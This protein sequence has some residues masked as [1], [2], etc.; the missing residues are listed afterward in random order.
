MIRLLEVEQSKLAHAA[1][2]QPAAR[3]NFEYGRVCGLYA[4]VAHAIDIIKNA[5]D[6]HKRADRG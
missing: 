3:D 2:V 1:L 5:A 6:E 4:G